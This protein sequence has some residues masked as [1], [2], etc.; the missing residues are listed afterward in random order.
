M[1]KGLVVTVSARFILPFCIKKFDVLL[2]Y[3]VKCYLY[4]YKL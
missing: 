1:Y 3:N 2:A 4:K